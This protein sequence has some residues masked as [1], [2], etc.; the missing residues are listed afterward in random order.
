VVTFS[1]KIKNGNGYSTSNLE[2]LIEALCINA[3]FDSVVRTYTAGTKIEACTAVI[4]NYRELYK[5]EV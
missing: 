3:S 5:A 2:Q 1:P 4:L